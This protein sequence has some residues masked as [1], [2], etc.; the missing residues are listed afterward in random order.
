M[1]CK[2]FYDKNKAAPIYLRGKIPHYIKRDPTVVLKAYPYVVQEKQTMYSFGLIVF[3]PTGQYLWT[4]IAE[5]NR[6][7]QPDE[8]LPGEIVNLPE[9]ILNDP[10]SRSLNYESTTKS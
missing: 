6:L 8:W 9:I 7:K 10:E 1:I 5:N 3:E 4:I 2:N